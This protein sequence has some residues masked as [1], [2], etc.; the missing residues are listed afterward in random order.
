V[1]DVQSF[2]NTL[3]TS[4][5]FIDFNDPDC[6]AATHDTLRSYQ[7]I[8]V[9]M[10][11]KTNPTLSFDP[12]QT[13]KFINSVVQANLQAVAALSRADS[14]RAF[15]ELQQRF[16]REYTTVLMQGVMT[17]VNATPNRIDFVNQHAHPTEPL[18][19]ILEA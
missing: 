18:I 17:I 9:M 13:M 6:N 19:I 16:V 2:S 1:K 8:G 10:F 11:R 15:V 5:S 12:M 3:S 4:G 7:K 14:S